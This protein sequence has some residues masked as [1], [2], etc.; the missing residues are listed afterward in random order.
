MTAAVVMDPTGHT[1]AVEW[2]FVIV[3]VLAL[4]GFVT[5]LV[6]R[7][8]AGEARGAAVPLARMAFS[9]RR[10]SGMP[11][12]AVG[13][14]WATSW[15][16]LVAGLGFYWDVAWHIDFGRDQ[17]LFT[18]P[19]TLI[20]LGLAGVL[21][22]GL[23]SIALA[24]VE[25]ADTG[26][27]IGR[28]RVPYAAVPLTLLGLGAVA[29]FPLDDIWHQNYG[30]DV[31]MWGPTHLMMIGGGALPGVAAWLLYAEAGRDAATP[32][33]RK[34]LER[35]LAGGLLLSLSVYQ[36][37]FDLGVPQWQALFQPLLIA[38]AC[39]VGMVAARVAL[40]RGWALIVGVNFVVSRGVVALVVGPGLGHTMPRFPL[41]LGSALLVE[42]VF[43]AGERR[44]TRPV[45]LALLAGAL[46]GTVGLASEWG[47]SHVWGR[48]PWQPSLLPGILAATGIAIAAALIGLA[49]G[50]VLSHRPVGVPRR[51]LLGAG[52][53]VVGLLLVAL[54]RTGGPATSA[55]IRTTQVG[56]AVP[57]IDRNGEVTVERSVLVDVRLDPA[58]AADGADVFRV[59]AWQGGG[60]HIAPLTQVEPGHWTAAEPVP[61]GGTWKDLVYLSS[62]DRIVAAP[63]SFP[64]DREYG[65]APVTLAAERIEPLVPASHWLMREAHGGAAWPAI[66]AYTG[67]LGMA[68]LWVASLVAGFW[69]VSADSAGRPPRLPAA[70]GRRS[71]RRGTTPALSG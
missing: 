52:V 3:P 17:Q 20:L 56:A 70:A 35:N 64:Q 67:L 13:G 28:L 25:A 42:T 9:L 29:G 49:I 10:I 59:V 53:A 47:F 69:A 41:Y 63:V 15:A 34:H 65:Q 57:A 5:N 12:W 7:G 40:G 36:L 14:I 6:A 50:R 62:G 23:L 33:L 2:L 16:L 22:A 60:L 43:A 48:Q 66:L 68:A 18:V 55:A 8:Q 39:G 51:A 45:R 4:V 31:T 1:T 11:A 38:L 46:V 19:H 27:R 54:P 44:G 24:T 58:T 37:E 71:R 32:R 61:T 26:W 21:G 30:I